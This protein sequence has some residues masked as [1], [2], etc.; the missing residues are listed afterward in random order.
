MRIVQIGAFPVDT[1]LIRGGV[2][3]SVYGLA[4]EQAK[5]SEV[6]VVDFP[7]MGIED[8]VEECEGMVV[9]RLHNPGPHQKDSRERIRA[10]VEIVSG[11][12]PDMC[13]I[14][15]TGLFS[16]ALY[17]RLKKASLPLI[18]TVHGLIGVEKK[19]A[20]K[21][22][23]AFKLLYQYINQSRAERLLIASQKT[24]IVDTG[25]VAEAVEGYRLSKTPRMSI[26]PQG[27]D[28]TFFGITCS[29]SSRTILSVGSFTKRKGHHLLIQAFGLAAEKLKDI[30]LVIC[31]VLTDRSYFQSLQALAAGLPC[32][33]RISLKPDLRKEEVFEQFR[34]A[35]I[36]ALHTQEESQG[37]VFAEAMATGLPIVSTNVGGVPFVVT[38][39]ENGFL[40]DYGNVEDF[41]QALINVLSMG[42]DWSVMSENCRK[43]S[44]DYSW[45]TIARKI[46]VEYKRKIE[47]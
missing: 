23:F 8:A 36:F 14:H 33:S 20:L 13:H 32:G 22:H 24:I 27:I 9:Y 26:I 15:G 37:I 1:S 40:T 31:G 6:Y 35:H 47:V 34:N 2:E 4:R 17:K 29:S 18:L 11:L 10:I 19:K 44:F 41:A 5:T 46:E 3:S 38:N 30:R 25:Y 45:E 7:R 39:G 43:A 12:K 21:Q 28:K 42:E 16:W